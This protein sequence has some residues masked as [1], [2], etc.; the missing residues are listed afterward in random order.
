MR[1]LLPIHWVLTEDEKADDVHFLNVDA[2]VGLKDCP[3]TTQR[4]PD[5][6]RRMMGQG[7]LEY[8]PHTQIRLADG[9]TIAARED[10]EVLCR[11]LEQECGVTILPMT[12]PVGLRQG[13]I[14]RVV[15]DPNAN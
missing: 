11:R 8:P 7:A 10:F 12:N 1:Y 2:I 14:R 5:A 3:E 6:V 15:E 13:V 9:N 4:Q